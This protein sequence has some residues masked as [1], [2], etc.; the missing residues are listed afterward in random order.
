[1][2]N[3]ESCHNQ[4][5]T[6]PRTPTGPKQ[7]EGCQHEIVAQIKSYEDPHSLFNDVLVL[8]YNLPGA[9]ENHPPNSTN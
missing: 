1:M 2:N 6:L 9:R 3:S 4:T 5:F 8:D 7:V